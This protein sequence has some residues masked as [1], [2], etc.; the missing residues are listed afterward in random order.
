VVSIDGAVL[1]EG[2]SAVTL[3]P[4]VSG[5]MP[6]YEYLWS[7][8]AT[9]PTIEVIPNNT[10][11]YSVT[12]TDLCGNEMISTADIMVIPLPT[13]TIS[14]YEQICPGAMMANLQV[15]FTGIGPWSFSY[16]VNNAAPIDINNITDNPYILQTNDLGIFT[17][18][19]VA[20]NG[21]EGT[22]QGV[23]TVEAISLNLTSSTSP[24][25]CPALE[26][27]SISV[28]VSN[29]QAPYNF[30]WDNPLAVGQNPNNL[31]TGNYNLL[32]TDANGCTI[33]L[34]ETVVLTLDVPTAT[35]GTADDLTCAVTQL[36]LT[37]TGA[38]GAL[39]S[40]NWS[41]TNGNILNGNN[42]FTPTINQ[43]GTYELTVTNVQTG[44]SVTDALTVNIDT[45]SPI[46]SVDALGPLMLDCEETSTV[47][48]GTG[49][50]PFGQIGFHW[51]TTDGDIPADQIDLP[52]IEVQSPGT[53]QLEVM[54]MNNGCM[55]MEEMAITQSVDLPI[56]N[57][58]AP[59]TLNCLVLEANIDATNSSTGSNFEYLW[60]TP[61][62]SILSGN[63][64][65]NLLVDAPGQY[66]ITITNN[67]NGCSED[68]GITVVEDIVAPVAEAGATP[69]ELDCNTAEVSL[70]GVNSSTGSSFS[71]SWTSA[72]GNI[73]SGNN[74][75]TP[76]VNA[77]GT[78]LLTVVNQANGCESS[79]VVTVEENPI[80]PDGMRLAV[81]EPLC[82]GDRGAV[83]IEEVFGGTLPFIFSIDGGLT[84]YGDTLFANLA[85]GN[86]SV[87]VQDAN[88][89]QFEMSTLIPDV[90]PLQLD[91]E[92]EVSISLGDSYQ[93][94]AFT[95]VP[96]NEIDTI[97]WS[98]DE[99][100]DCSNCLDPLARPLE[101]TLYG[102]LLLDTNGCLVEAE[103]FLRVD[104]ERDIFI[105]NAFSPN[106][107]G[108]NDL[109]MIFANNKSIKAVN[110]LQ[111][112]NRWGEQVFQQNNFMPN[113]PDY[114]WNGYFKGEQVNPSVLVYF[115]EVEFIDGFKKMYKGDVTLMK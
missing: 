25:S 22:V 114:G 73:L 49:S 90:L 107:D 45:L 70:D 7:N 86:V 84:F 23:A 37:G 16:S 102:I 68:G 54:N 110:E 94:E 76:T 9:T 89:C 113:D 13:A 82:H 83:A 65:L 108:N 15:A 63:T 66:N 58:E 115:A 88:G 6:G 62:G 20:E 3:S 81:T 111:L 8:N 17:L 55:D 5:G 53:Y 28:Q 44:C 50:L 43:P 18:T 34:S 35:A 92:A 101:S 91:L 95:N 42:T 52:T 51:S 24:V 93:I 87:I 104:K 98:P 71:Y 97:I 38:T 41:T 47:L 72:D 109:F 69:E 14:G 32:V 99:T 103:I 39:Y 57:I 96:T 26:D 1:C 100:L 40:P 11:A 21:C 67:A 61:N 74:S 106:G 12:V 79:D 80:M 105:P 36:T 78:Y 19:V 2:A 46:A 48:S 85:P 27:G 64:T 4:Q 60:S 59:L 29:G 30:A 33:T 31:P 75:L 10:T 112:F 56:V 77:G